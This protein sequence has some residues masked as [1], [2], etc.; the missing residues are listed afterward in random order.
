MTKHQ[1]QT[2]PGLARRDFLTAAAAVAVGAHAAGAQ[3]KKAVQ[4]LVLQLNGSSPTGRAR[5]GKDAPPV[6]YPDPDVVV[7]DDRFK[8]YKLGNSAIRRVYHSKD[9]LW[10]EGPAWNGVGRYLLWS[11]IPNNVQMRYLEEDGH[12]STF[13]HP[14]GNSNG[15]TFDWSGRQIAC[16]HGNRRVV[17][18]EYDGTIT[19]LAHKVNGNVTGGLAPGAPHRFHDLL[20]G[21]RRDGTT[22]ADEEGAVPGRN[23]RYIAFLEFTANEIVGG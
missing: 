23:F 14:S 7:L 10:A 18:Y 5:Y 8:K 1:K 15:N 20:A 9:M 19:V 4:R 6:R 22:D 12:V 3:D 13:R 16:E 21:V 2:T 11:D 17:R